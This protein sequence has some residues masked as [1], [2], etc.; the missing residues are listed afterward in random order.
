MSRN[1]HVLMPLAAG[2]LF[3]L[4]ASAQDWAQWR[5]PEGT[6]ISNE[7]QWESTGREDALWKAEVGV[8]YTSFVI[9]DGRVITAGHQDGKDTDTIFCF[10]ATNGTE[11]WS[12]SYPSKKWD[13]S[14][15]GG[16][17]STP[18]IDDDHVYM[19]NR[20]GLLMCLNLADGAEV[21]TNHLKEAYDLDYPIWMFS[22]SPLISGD[23]VIIN[24]GRTIAFA[25]D[26]GEEIWQTGKSGQAYSTPYPLN[27]K[28]VPCLAVFNSEGL[29]I[30]NRSEGTELAS[31]EW[32]T[33]Y[34][35]NAA[36]PIVMGNRIFISSGQN[37][38][39][40]ML[41]LTNDGL[42]VVWEN[43]TMANK[44]TGC[45]LVND[46]L[47]GF[48]NQTLKCI[49]LDGNEKWAERGLGNGTLMASDGRLIVI[50]GKG[51]LIVADASPGGFT[52][53]S[54]TR[55]LEGGVFWTMPV[56]ANGL[57]YCRNSLGDI[58]CRDHRPTGS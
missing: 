58:V 10:D 25:K 13:N 51:D 50:S 44:M 22:A 49:D 54:Q 55:V 16:T 23:M 40:A 34:D 9:S 48:D 5:G 53:L 7:N 24:V 47:F 30:Y 4:S 33:Q 2:L 29:Y 17:L 28:G 6:G 3:T 32:K 12:H 39:C 1:P 27:F 36:T 57:I 43:K 19:L 15:V 42:E 38:G 14:H 8:G 21:W 35:I 18:T 26:T 31:H 37:R 20:E 45:V 11:I 56:L 41:E 46:H 52:P